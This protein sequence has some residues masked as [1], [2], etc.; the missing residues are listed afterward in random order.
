MRECFGRV[1]YSH[2]T[3]HKCADFALNRLDLIKKS[4]IGLSALTTGGFLGILFGDGMWFAVAGTAVSTALLALNTYSKD[5]NLGEIAERH[6][7]AASELWLIRE[8]Y[9]SLLSD[10]RSGFLSPEDARGQRDTL[11]EQLGAVYAGAP[12][13]NARAYRE[14]QNALQNME[15]LTFSDSEIDAFLP[16]ALRKGM[17]SDA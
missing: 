3:H 14:A 10:L 7:Q 11:L 2:K 5:Y 16:R 12:N 17:S 13:T 8:K 9:L 1:V 15:E 6:R 4:Q